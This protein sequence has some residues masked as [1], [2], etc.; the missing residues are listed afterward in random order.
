MAA[1]VIQ[2]PV[3]SI[4]YTASIC[5]GLA[6]LLCIAPSIHSQTVPANTPGIPAHKSTPTQGDQRIPVVDSVVTPPRPRT[7]EQSPPSAPRVDWDGHQLSIRCENATLADVLVAVRERI[8]AT[9]DLPPGAAAERVALD[10]GPGPAREVLTDLLSGSRFNYVIVA[11]ESNDEI[12]ASVVLSPL[13]KS[14]DDVNSSLS[15]LAS[16]P[17]RPLGYRPS[18]DSVEAEPEATSGDT[19]TQAAETTKPSVD[20][21]TL[22]SGN[23]PVQGSAAPT[24]DVAEPPASPVADG[25]TSDISK[26]SIAT[27]PSADAGNAGQAGSSQMMKDLQAMYEQRRRLQAQQNQSSSGQPNSRNP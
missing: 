20:A 2:E 23:T 18:Q 1:A 4:T 11:S 25:G 9:I 26:S 15:A 5:A 16:Q 7:P 14:P 21:D 13:G 12:V 27:A 6:L 17:R 3:T 24:P 8:K 10:L 19:S 22:R